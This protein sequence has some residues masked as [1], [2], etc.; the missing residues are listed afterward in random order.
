MPTTLDRPQLEDAA[1]HT[2]E[3]RIDAIEEQTSRIASHEALLLGL[4]IIVLG[5]LISMAVLLVGFG[6]NPR[7][8]GSTEQS[9]A[10]ADATSAGP[11]A[12]DHAPATDARVKSE[13]Y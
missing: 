13:A 8:S 9:S 12:H 10:P 6:S 5:A 7:D 3:E 2:E 1:T 4:V 11:V